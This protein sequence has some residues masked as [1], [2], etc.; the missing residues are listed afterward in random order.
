MDSIGFYVSVIS[1]I[2]LTIS[3]T[4]PYIEKV[5]SN[6]IIQCIIETIRHRGLPTR[7]LWP[8]D[9]HQQI[10]KLEEQVD[11]IQEQVDT[12]QEQQKHKLVI[13]DLEKDKKMTIV[14]ES[15]R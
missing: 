9:L 12:I 3:E 6:G 15:T 2:L 5:K 1:S 13:T 7:L 4:L 14:I 8:D 11:T 10:N